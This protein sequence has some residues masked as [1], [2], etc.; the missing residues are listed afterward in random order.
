MDIED[1]FMYRGVRYRKKYIDA[2]QELYRTTEEANNAIGSTDQP[3]MHY[4]SPESPANR[5]FGGK[6]GS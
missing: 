2:F 6:D 4:Q 1:S 3:R 5:K